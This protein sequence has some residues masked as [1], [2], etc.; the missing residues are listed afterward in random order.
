[1]SCC[2]KKAAKK[3]DRPP[4]TEES[5]VQVQNEAS[6]SVASLAPEP[7]VVPSLT[8]NSASQIQESYLE[9][10]PEEVT[11]QS[12]QATPEALPRATSVVSSNAFQPMTPHMETRSLRMN[13]TESVRSSAI[14]A[15]G[16]E[17]PQSAAGVLDFT[18][19]NF[20]SERRVSD[21]SQSL[22][23]YSDVAASLLNSSA[24]VGTSRSVPISHHSVP[25][26]HYSVQLSHQSSSNVAPFQNP[27]VSPS[28]FG[29]PF[30]RPST[31]EVQGVQSLENMHGFIVDT[32]KLRTSLARESAPLFVG[33]VRVSMQEG[34]LNR[35]LPDASVR[36]SFARTLRNMPI[37]EGHHIPVRKY[38][39]K[40]SADW[41][42]DM[43]KLVQ[44]GKLRPW[45]KTPTPTESRATS[46]AAEP[47]E[48]I[49]ID[50]EVVEEE[51]VVVVEKEPERKHSFHKLLP[52]RVSGS[53]AS[54]RS[55]AAHH[56]GGY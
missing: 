4:I 46:K 51:V 43:S 54:V 25:L 52:E 3:S 19:G 2:G 24:F 1:M 41:N 11:L 28:V 17:G 44:E 45:P 34:S 16:S 7:S 14:Q 55:K 12:G 8:H 40:D 13:G 26:S 50:E 5:A 15:L 22:T 21:V 48:V 20:G 35:T 38:L 23:G 10:V 37:G 30:M 53:R 18:F 33:D 39:S 29:Q 6:L 9:G 56:F 27:I 42:E 32:L 47:E 49:E 31:V 36:A